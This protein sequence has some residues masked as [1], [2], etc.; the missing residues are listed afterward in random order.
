MIRKAYHWFAFISCKLQSVSEK[1][2]LP[3]AQHGVSV[4]EQSS[5][6]TKWCLGGACGLKALWAL[7]TEHLPH[8]LQQDEV[9]TWEQTAAVWL[10]LLCR[11]TDWQYRRNEVY[12]ESIHCEWPHIWNIIDMIHLLWEEYWMSALLLEQLTNTETELFHC[13]LRVK[14]STLNY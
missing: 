9:S 14:C 7:V 1:W 2:K 13:D 5:E 12:H 3:R 10:L 8:N 6:R 11:E 4:C